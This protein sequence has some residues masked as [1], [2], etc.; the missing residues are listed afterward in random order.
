MTRKDSY[1]TIASN[2]DEKLIRNMVESLLK[3][4]DADKTGMADFALETSGIVL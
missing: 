2:Q 4:Y 1:V 3:K